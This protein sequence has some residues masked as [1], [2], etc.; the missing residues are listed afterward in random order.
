[1][2]IAIEQKSKLEIF[3]EIFQTIKKWNSSVQIVFQTDG[4]HIQTMDRS[5]VCL[6]HLYIHNQWFTQYD[7]LSSVEQ[8]IYLDTSQFAIILNYAL[9]HNKLEIIYS[10]DDPDKVNINLLNSKEY[11]SDHYDHFFELTQIDGENETLEIP[12]LDYNVD[13]TFESKKLSEILN[14]LNVFGTD[15]NIKCSETSL[16][17]LS[18]GGDSGKMKVIVPIDDLN[19][20]AIAEGEVIDVT[21]SLNHV[22]KMCISSK[23]SSEVQISI[24]PDTPMLIKYDLGENS[25]I[26]F[27]VAPKIL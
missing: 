3:V 16:E 26:Q 20:F 15:L 13:I 9:K 1:M 7:L 2:I 25:L 22:G 14:E 12:E 11:K 24:S 27:F 23:L 19:E 10:D 17:I 8:T 21:Y 4:M 6:C 18:S 5:H